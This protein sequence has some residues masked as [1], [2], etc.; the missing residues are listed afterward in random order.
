MHTLLQVPAE[1]YA[2]ATKLYQKIENEKFISTLKKNIKKRGVIYRQLF[3]SFTQEFTFIINLIIFIEQYYYFKKN[4]V[5][6][7][8]CNIILK[9]ILE[10]N[11]AKAKHY[12]YRLYSY[13][14]LSQSNNFILINI[15]H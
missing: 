9:S 4:Y 12:F 13:F 11:S 3:T 5:E 2:L 14:H 15:P 1:D 8:Y 7:K 10:L 6:S